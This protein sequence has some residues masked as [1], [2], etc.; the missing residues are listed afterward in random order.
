MPMNP[1]QGQIVIRPELSEIPVV[2]HYVRDWLDNTGVSGPTRD[3]LLLVV[4]ELTAGAVFA[5]PANLAVEISVRH[6][7]DDIAIDVANC[8]PLP[9]G[10]DDDVD[11]F[12]PLDGYSTDGLR[13]VRAFTD[14][15]HAERYPPV[16]VVSCR[17][18][19]VA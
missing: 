7:N 6:E 10:E 1:S 12:D 2:R 4:T 13:I 9:V 19:D 3:E 16:T 8:G 5:S 14:Q 15:L 11:A 17:R 18:H